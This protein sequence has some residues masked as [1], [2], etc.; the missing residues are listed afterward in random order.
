MDLQ[1]NV[2][3]G[4]L[5]ISL[6]VCLSSCRSLSMSMSWSFQDMSWGSLGTVRSYSNFHADRDA[7]EIQT[8][9]EQ[10]DANNLVRILTNRSYVQRKQILEVYQSITEKD[11]VA[12]VK[13]AVSGDLATLLLG[14]MMTPL[15]FQAH[16]LRMAMEG[17]G[18]DEET[19]LE[20]LCTTSSQ[21]LKDISA[22]YNTIFQ[23]DLE[24]DLKGESSGDFT[25]LLMALLRREE[26]VGG[27]QTDTDAL[28]QALDAKKADPWI[29]IL[30]T[31][32]PDHLNKVLNRLESEREQMVDE[33]LQKRFSGDLKLGLRTLVCCIRNP[34]VY[35]AQRLENM[36]TAVVQGVMVARCEEDLLCVRAA[37]LRKTGTSLY[38][39]LQKP[40]TGDHLQALLAICRSE[41]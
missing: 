14:L 39:A 36:E 22:A 38:T 16:R 12:G 29:A 1:R 37:F 27:L 11:L 30:T 9:L 17:L 32:N 20:I 28:S 5:F 19:L 10:K 3:L 34:H 21:Q 23:K 18:T 15:H 2:I 25:K 24:K 31:R 26:S 7:L 13:K 8:A 35:L 41:D 33:A 40:F 6:S 4:Y